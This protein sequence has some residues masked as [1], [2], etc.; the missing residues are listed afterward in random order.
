MLITLNFLLHGSPLGKK[1]VGAGLTHTASKIV[2]RYGPLRAIF[3]VMYSIVMALG[4]ILLY[5]IFFS[6]LTYF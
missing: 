4:E 3:Q 1:L 2:S 6:F 5:F